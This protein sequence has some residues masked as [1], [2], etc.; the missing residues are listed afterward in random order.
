MRIPMTHAKHLTCLWPAQDHVQLE[1]RQASSD[2][3][4]AGS[5]QTFT[6]PARLL[7]AQ[8]MR[9]MSAACHMSSPSTALHLTTTSPTCGQHQHC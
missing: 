5:C 6:F 9:R 1:L 8:R 2:M 4:A 3:A 7:M